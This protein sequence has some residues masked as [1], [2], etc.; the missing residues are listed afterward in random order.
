MIFFSC[1]KNTKNYLSIAI[2]IMPR[3]TVIV[4]CTESTQKKAH[5]ICHVRNSNLMPFLKLSSL[6][7]LLERIRNLFIMVKK[8][9]L[10]KLK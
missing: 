7:L 2:L 8:R 6:F 3:H 1:K 10:W 4:F 5:K 9:I